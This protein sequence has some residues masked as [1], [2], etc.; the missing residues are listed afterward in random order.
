[1]PPV[2]ITHEFCGCL[3]VPMTK[4]IMEIFQQSKV[5][6]LFQDNT[7][8]VLHA[9]EEL[10]IP[11]KRAWSLSYVQVFVPWFFLLYTCLTG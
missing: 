11:K 6:G 10:T 5:V 2:E 7:Q 9:T 8:P 3:Q 4:L 1:M